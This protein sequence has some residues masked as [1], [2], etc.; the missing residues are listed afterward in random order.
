MK[1]ATLRKLI[2]LFILPLLVLLFPYLNR[3][4][5]QVTTVTPNLGTNIHPVPKDIFGFNGMNT[6]R[7]DQSWGDMLNNTNSQTRLQALNARVLRYPGG[8]LGNYWD[9][10][11]G[12]F[13]DKYDLQNGILLPE[14]YNPDLPVSTPPSV[15]DNRL[16]TFISCIA[17]S[18]ATP[19]WQL[20]VLSSD[21][22]YQ[23]GSLYAARVAGVR[24]QYVELG[25]ELYL[26][27]TDN[28]S[29]FPN[30]DTYSQLAADWAAEIKSIPP[31][32]TIKIAALGAESGSTDEP[33]RRQL[34]LEGLMQKIGGNQDISAV[35][36]HHYFPA[37]LA[38]GNNGLECPCSSAPITA[39]EYGL[40]DAI[41][42]SREMVTDE[43]GKIANYGK[44]VWIT[45][46][47]LFDTKHALHGSW[48]HALFTTAMLMTYL[49]GE[50]VTKIMPHTLAGEGIFS[51][52]FSTNTGLNFGQNGGSF[53]G[54]LFCQSTI[55]Y[56][57]RP[58]EFTGLGNAISMITQAGN[59]VTS[60]NNIEFPGASDLH[61]NYS[62]IKELQ[63]WYFQKDPGNGDFV[64]V[65]YS[66]SPYDIDMAPLLA[67][68]GT[69]IGS[70]HIIK[71]QSIYADPCEF[72]KGNAINGIISNTDNE[73]N[74]STP[75]AVTTTPIR[76]ERFSIT[77][78][79][80]RPSV[81]PF[82][83]VSIN[84]TEFCCNEAL[85]IYARDCNW[86]EG[87]YWSFDGEP[88]INNDN[89]YY[90]E[91]PEMNE[92]TG[93]NIALHNSSGDIIWNQDITIFRCPGSITI[94]SPISEFCPGDEVVLNSTAPTNYPNTWNYHW[95]PTKPLLNKDVNVHSTSAFP[96]HTTMFRQ[97]ATDGICWMKSND[98]IINSSNP[99]PYF[100]R[101]ELQVCNTITNKNVKLE[102]LLDNI[103]SPNLTYE[104][105]NENGPLTACSTNVCIID[106]KDE[107]FA[108][109]VVVTDNLT[110]CSG[111]ADMK[112]LG[113]QCCDA[114]VSASNLNL[115]GPP[116]VSLASIVSDIIS[117]DDEIARALV[118]NG[119]SIPGVSNSTSDLIIDCSGS[120]QIKD[121]YINRKLNIDKNTT[122][123]GCQLNMVKMPV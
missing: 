107:D 33:G 41:S 112:V 95:T 35:T 12:W 60:V 103:Q 122:L 114:P 118:Q 110:G 99:E 40:A 61:Q 109:R 25:N 98:L 74:L 113:V 26:T 91:I 73:A 121:I 13:L 31:F 68:N 28:R 97:Y 76:L 7:A 116:V 72:I 18:H 36:L 2:V 50:N 27:H 63:G 23:I 106:H 45:E 65:N 29:V 55:N 34:W 46:F 102:A 100:R 92:T 81:P 47:N 19:M 54:P 90:F 22:K 71:W 57:T 64:I 123:I 11:K 89:P 42:I 83:P 87:Y 94:S 37:K 66:D 78:I 88:V 67:S 101:N 80:V 48:F 79:T 9:W 10:R 30:V 38:P 82:I 84:E 15:F 49:E 17:Q 85:S 111:E 32:N 70:N 96:E 8:T 14:N 117:I 108:I 21:S 24:K 4:E 120:N 5:A 53:L 62:G 3:L 58:W 86:E 105:F 56:A 69:P 6:I 59:G 77:R 115:S 44:E 52:I 104:W 1:N 16:E 119:G 20:N 43:I 39:F 93:K 75:T 51:G